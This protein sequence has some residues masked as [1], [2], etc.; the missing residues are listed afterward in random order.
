MPAARRERPVPQTARGLVAW[1]GR[2][3]RRA[4]LA[5]GH[6]TDNARD[7][8]V[9][10]V[11]HALGLPF[12]CAGAELD[13][14]RQPAE[15]AAACALVD[16]RI[17]TR[18]PAAYLTGRMWFAGLEFAVDDRVLVPRSPIAELIEAGYGPWIDPARVS[19]VLDIGT[20]CGCIAIAS[21]VRLPQATVDATDVSPDALA[22]AEANAGR[23]RVAARVR[24]HRADLWPDDSGPW[25]VIVSNPPYVRDG[26]IAGFPA[27]YLHEPR[28]GHAGGADG[29]DIVRRIVA[30][31]RARLAPGGI[32]VCEVGAEAAAVEAQWPRVPF[33]WIEFARGGEGVFVVARDELPA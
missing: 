10:L 33:T 19:R 23:L 2:R 22:L 25:D 14:P 20:G 1:A 4:G 6:G 8:A 7:E 15:L 26:V 11:F 27:E 16:E 32:L 30:G 28:L 13:R 31:A 17:R 29:L 12:D 5:Y 21:A 9:F 24:L 3:L 18:R